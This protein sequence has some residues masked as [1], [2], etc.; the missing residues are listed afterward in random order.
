MFEYW[1]NDSNKYSTLKLSSPSEK[2]YLIK[3][4]SKNISTS[5]L[6]TL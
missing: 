5:N 3:T 6:S 4:V 1:G 2:D